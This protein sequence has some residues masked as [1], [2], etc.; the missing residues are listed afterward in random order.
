MQR[1][2]SVEKIV[3]THAPLAGSDAVLPPKPCKRLAVSTHAPL[4]GSDAESYKQRLFQFVSTHAPL[5]GSDICSI[6]VL[7]CGNVSTHAPLAGSDQRNRNV[8]FGAYR[9][10][11]RSPCGERLNSWFRLI[12]LQTFQPTLPLRG[13]TT[14]SAYWVK[15][16]N[17]FNPRSPCG[18]RLLP[19]TYTPHAEGFNPRSPCGERQRPPP[20]TVSSVLFQPTLPLRGA[21]CGRRPAL[22]GAWVSTHAPLAGS[23]STFLDMIKTMLGFNPRSPC[24]ERPPRR[25]AWYAIPGFN[26]RSPCGER[27]HTSPTTLPSA[28]FNPRSP[29]GERRK[30]LCLAHIILPY[31]TLKQNNLPQE[32][33]C[34]GSKRR[35]RVRTDKGNHERLPFALAFAEPG[36]QFPRKRRPAPSASCSPTPPQN[37]INP[38]AS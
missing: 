22:P 15:F 9:F 25:P 27:L 30:T 20:N 5:A 10:N 1:L 6:S 11:P 4:A 16:S 17:G 36:P 18:E 32:P 34:Q 2:A 33:L 31:K 28:G 12:K 26:P 19:C 38:S 24:G 13:A 29:C 35:K 3:S 14:K 37:E 21:T 23:D 7:V 8:E